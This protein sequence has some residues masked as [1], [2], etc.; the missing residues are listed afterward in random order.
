[1][2][3]T[4]NTMTP[5]YVKDTRAINGNHKGNTPNTL[6]CAGR[7]KG[8]RHAIRNVFILIS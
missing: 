4:Y 5:N 8:S 2:K 1:M 7:E 3:N 6:H